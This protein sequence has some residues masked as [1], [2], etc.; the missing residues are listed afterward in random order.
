MGSRVNIGVKGQ[1]NQ[2]ILT[3]TLE[4]GS[5][6]TG[7][8]SYKIQDLLCTLIEGPELNN[9]DTGISRSQRPQPH[10]PVGLTQ[11]INATI[12]LLPH[13]DLMLVERGAHTSDLERGGAHS[14]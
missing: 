3:H 5:G 12:L 7:I 9:N 10:I 1:Y 4:L 14:W 13:S 6:F 11:P 8:S 2:C